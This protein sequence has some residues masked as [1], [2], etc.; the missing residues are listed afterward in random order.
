MLQWRKTS[1]CWRRFLS[2]RPILTSPKKKVHRD[3]AKEKICA[4]CI[5]VGVAPY[6]L[7]G[8]HALVCS[9]KSSFNVCVILKI[10]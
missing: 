3:C 7:Q 10:V 5:M 6:F 1:S 4:V 2:K 9:S 8:T